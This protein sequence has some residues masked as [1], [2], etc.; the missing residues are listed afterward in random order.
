M[1][2]PSVA[3]AQYKNTQLVSQFLQHN[4]HVDATL[5]LSQEISLKKLPSLTERQKKLL[6]D[7]LHRRI[8]VGCSD[9]NALFFV[10]IN[11][12]IIKVEEI[13]R[14]FNLEITD[15]CLVGSTAQSILESDPAFFAALDRSLANECPDAPFEGF[16]FTPN[17]QDIRVYFKKINFEQRFQVSEQLLGFYVELIKN[18]NCDLLARK[19]TDAYL[20]YHCPMI[21]R[22]IQDRINKVISFDKRSPQFEK[23]ISEIIQELGFRPRDQEEINFVVSRASERILDHALKKLY[24]KIFL[25]VLDSLKNGTNPTLAKIL[26]SFALLVPKNEAF[27]KLSNQ[28]DTNPN[29]YFIHS[30]KGGIE[31]MGI[32]SLE[33]SSQLSPDAP[34]I[35]LRSKELVHSQECTQ[36]TVD[37]RFRVTRIIQ[38]TTY[39]IDLLKHCL[40]LTLGLDSA[41]PT[42]EHL[43]V[44]A[45]KGSL[46]NP[47]EIKKFREFIDLQSR[48]DPMLYLIFLFNCCTSLGKL[49]RTSNFLALFKKLD[50]EKDSIEHVFAQ[51]LFSTRTP[52]DKVQYLL[53]VLGVIYLRKKRNPKTGVEYILRTDLSAPILKL[54][55]NKS[56]RPFFLP[57]HFQPILSLDAVCKWFTESEDFRKSFHRLYRLILGS[58]ANPAIEIQELTIELSNLKRLNG[59][60]ERNLWTI[61]FSLNPP[62]PFKE[63]LRK[64]AEDQQLFRVI[65][66]EELQIWL[67]APLGKRKETV[68]QM[69]QAGRY[70]TAWQCVDSDP[71]MLEVVCGAILEQSPESR[72]LQWNLSKLSNYATKLTSEQIKAAAEKSVSSA[73]RYSSNNSL[74]IQW[75]YVCIN[76][77]V[78]IKWTITF[79][80]EKFGSL[81]FNGSIPSIWKSFVP[82]AINCLWEERKSF[83]LSKF[84][85]WC[86][87]NQI[88]IDL[89]FN[90]L[91]AKCLSM[92]VTHD[93]YKLSR[94]I[95]AQPQVMEKK[96]Q[97]DDL[98]IYKQDLI[99]L[100]KALLHQGDY[101][102]V[103]ELYN[104]V[105]KIN[106]FSI[107]LNELIVSFLAHTS[108]QGSM[109]GVIVCFTHLKDRMEFKATAKR[110]LDQY[111]Q[112]R[113]LPKKEIEQILSLHPELTPQNWCQYWAYR[114]SVI[115][116]Y[117]VESLDRS[118]THQWHS[119]FHDEAYWKRNKLL[120][121]QAIVDS[122]E[123]MAESDLVQL[124][125]DLP[126]LTEISVTPSMESFVLRF[127]QRLNKLRSCSIEQ[128]KHFRAVRELSDATTE[129]W[130]EIDE[131]FLQ[132][133]ISKSLLQEACQ[134]FLKLFN[135]CY[136]ESYQIF[137]VRIMTA[138]AAAKESP[139]ILKDL[140]EIATKKWKRFYHPQLITILAKSNLPLHREIVQEQVSLILHNPSIASEYILADLNLLLV[141]LLK[142]DPSEEILLKVENLF[143]HSIFRGKE[144]LLLAAQLLL[145]KVWPTYR[146]LLLH[147]NLAK[148]PELGERFTK[149]MKLLPPS[150]YLNEFYWTEAVRLIRDLF[151]LKEYRNGL[152]VNNLIVKT[153]CQHLTV[154]KHGIECFDKHPSKHYHYHITPL[155]CIVILGVGI[156]KKIPHFKEYIP[157]IMKFYQS[158]FDELIPIQTAIQDENNKLYVL[159]LT[160]VALNCWGS[161]VNHPSTN[162]NVDF[163]LQLER[164]IYSYMPSNK[165][166]LIHIAKSHA[167][168]SW[169]H[170]ESMKVEKSKMQEWIYYTAGHIAIS[171]DPKTTHQ[172]ASHNERLQI[173]K[174]VFRKLVAMNDTYSL[175]Y[176]MNLFINLCSCE[177]VKLSSIAILCFDEIADLFVT[178]A[179]VMTYFRENPY[180]QFFWNSDIIKNP[181]SLQGTS[182]PQC[183]LDTLERIMGV[184]PQLQYG[185]VNIERAYLAWVDKLLITFCNKYD[186]SAILLFDHVLEILKPKILKT[187]DE[188]AR[189]L[190]L[191]A[192]F[193]LLCSDLIVK[194]EQ[195]SVNRVDMIIRYLHYVVENFPGNSAFIDKTILVIFMRGY[196]RPYPSKFM[197]LLA[198]LRSKG[199]LSNMYVA[200]TSI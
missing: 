76:S 135:S 172:I 14:K 177:D 48:K 70:D 176:L 63:A 18:Q 29:R 97:G 150:I 95:A 8:P 38:K 129:E 85:E 200:S 149:F 188:T 65:H 44:D 32:D 127:L 82:K 187:Q 78:A 162:L 17:D 45:F 108:D 115:G 163:S 9:N 54:T 170:S 23:I 158:L 168:V 83:Q 117:P 72:N 41:C 105:G 137:Y 140:H 185:D 28:K 153:F 183:I 11:D 81:R 35:S 155:E 22:S 192:Y 164:F 7:L 16:P 24:S 113:P 100:A 110:L 190:I 143:S 138:S 99:E 180:P 171:K 20:N 77:N 156:P 56:N 184:L 142:N 90:I 92:H 46:E 122:I 199:E 123:Y 106:D 124:A 79:I 21:K 13:A 80:L 169:M 152:L 66:I 68:L 62:H 43:L 161:L 157:F 10:S 159:D 88:Q 102:A 31:L 166:F 116:E 160:L 91:R 1:T 145:E 146:E 194:T 151:E 107:Q 104:H 147:H 128:L 119:I 136:K 49:S 131:W 36:G 30:L 47:A 132:L 27:K 51:L 118:L 182:I 114:K 15:I 60:T 42:D 101:K 148:H 75:L 96:L 197:D 34:Q 71:E 37:R 167:L 130:T 86:S 193:Q 121:V 39:A 19:V 112:N 139:P 103:L 165:C 53:V 141:D 178:K 89:T 25:Q 144:A 173:L 3:S 61:A 59:R 73:P 84:F 55:L 133:Y 52:L 191:E 57:L 189:F 4:G 2:T 198:Y 40:N 50:Y 134:L 195:C 174:S 64:S 26:K 67:N 186:L 33:R 120:Q 93:A 69:C 109:H 98:A 111:F 5:K 125:S 94:F 175:G 181:E 196:N 12:L 126:L 154:S 58:E 87:V 74:P 179:E 6:Q